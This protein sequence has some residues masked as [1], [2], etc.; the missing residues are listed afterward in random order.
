MSTA[1]ISTKSSILD[2]RRA[3]AALRS[4]AA[5]VP[6]TAPDYEQALITATIW[7]FWWLLINMRSWVSFCKTYINRVHVTDLDVTDRQKQSLFW[8]LSIFGCLLVVVDLVSIIHMILIV[9]AAHGSFPGLSGSSESSL[10]CRAPERW[11]EVLQTEP[12][13]TPTIS[14]NVQE[15]VCEQLAT[16]KN[17]FAHRRSK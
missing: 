9:T 7:W 17:E 1:S 4:P 12:I 13:T 6:P 16:C 11:R 10:S 2:D 8:R 5:L 14:S 15:H 3:S